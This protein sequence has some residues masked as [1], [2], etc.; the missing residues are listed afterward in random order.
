MIWRVLLHI[1][2]GLVVMAAAAWAYGTVLPQSAALALG[3]G[4]G[5]L[6]MVAPLFARHGISGRM[7]FR[8]GVPLI[9]W[10]I[11]GLLLEW[12]PLHLPWLTGVVIASGVA[13]AAGAGTHSHAQGRDSSARIIESLVAVAIPLYAIIIAL[14]LDASALDMALAAAG[15][16]VGCVVAYQSRTWPGRH[17]SALLMSAAACACVAVAWI[18][19]AGVA[20]V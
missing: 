13:S 15:A 5:S 17:E 14:V 20:F 12:R 11:A 2:V 19:V 3:I 18:V 8:A 4:L 10:P 6:E 9:V 1:A 7:I 16:A